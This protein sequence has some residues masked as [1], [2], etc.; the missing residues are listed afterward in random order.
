[1]GLSGVSNMALLAYL[2]LIS[3]LLEAV[4]A[5]H[6]AVPASRRKPE[7][8]CSV[9][10]L[11]AASQASCV[12]V[13]TAELC[14]CQEGL[15][16][17]EILE[18]LLSRN[19][20]YQIE[21]APCLGACGGGAMVSIDFEDGTYALVAG[22]DETLFE[23]G[24]SDEN[25]NLITDN[26]TQDDYI[27]QQD[28]GGKS[29]SSEEIGVVS[30]RAKAEA[31]RVT[32]SILEAQTN[33]ESSETGVT[34][35]VIVSSGSTDSGAPVMKAEAESSETTS[36]SKSFGDVRDRMRAEAAKEEQINPWLNAASYLAK[37]AGER[38]FSR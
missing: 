15:G 11:A 23:L 36:Q 22:I 10:S 30:G 34:D 17:D 37:K 32:T 14:N 25:N 20:P 6:S 38:I 1:M 19:L 2:V 8:K 33:I 29:I 21:E 9:T 35:A 3:L 27:A 13:C 24:L 5:F 16:G 18:N 12:S 7:L 26:E 31:S 28:L 4:S